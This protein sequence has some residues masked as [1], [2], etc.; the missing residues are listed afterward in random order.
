MQ[1]CRHGGTKGGCSQLNYIHKEQ[2]HSPFHT[3]ALEA[4]MTHND[5]NATITLV[6]DPRGDYV[7]WANGKRQIRAALKSIGWTAVGLFRP[8]KENK[9]EFS[10]MAK[11]PM[12]NLHHI[13]C[14]R[15]PHAI[16]EQT[17]IIA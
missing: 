4:I 14:A 8:R 2:T 16:I 5:K 9:N 11:D 17:L 10:I 12:G 13:K 3:Q 7:T 6:P 1:I 15:K